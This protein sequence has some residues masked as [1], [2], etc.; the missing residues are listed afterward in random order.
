MN[1]KHLSHNVPCGYVG[2]VQIVSIGSGSGDRFKVASIVLV[3]Y[4]NRP[5]EIFFHPSQGEA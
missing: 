3:S 4:I 2:I 1:N 5:T